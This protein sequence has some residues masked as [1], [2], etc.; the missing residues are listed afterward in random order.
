MVMIHHLGKNRQRN[1]C[2][3][4]PLPRLEMVIK[5]IDQN[6][7][8]SFVWRA[9]KT[10]TQVNYRVRI[11]VSIDFVMQLDSALNAFGEFRRD[12]SSPEISDQ[13]PNPRFGCRFG[14]KKMGQVVHANLMLPNL[15][16]W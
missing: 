16:T 2:K 5:P 7:G 15:G 6:P 9:D 14:Q 10:F 4:R 3:V 12:G 1:I 11:G 8:I 13:I